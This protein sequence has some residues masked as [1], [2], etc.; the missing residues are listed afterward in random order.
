MGYFT[1]VVTIICIIYSSDIIVSMAEDIALRLHISEKV[2]TMFV[3]VIG[4]SLPEMVMT[5]TSAKKGEFD[6]AIGNIIGTNIFNICIV[7]GL[8]VIIYGNVLLTGFGMI[9]IIMVF[10]SSVL[11]VFFARSEKTID[12]KEAIIML[13][14]FV[15]YYFFLLIEGY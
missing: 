6:I 8:P 11:L 1:I 2:I 14:L 7:L 10:L 5:V 4:T 13:A 9:D 15:L 12:K 3:I